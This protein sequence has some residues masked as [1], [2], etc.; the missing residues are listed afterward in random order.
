MKKVTIIL[1]I[2]LFIF[3]AQSYSQ[4]QKK[5]EKSPVK[6]ALLVID[7]QKAYLQSIS[8]SDRKIAFHYING[9]IDLF[10]KNGF[11]V[12]RIYHYSKE[13]G[14][15]QGSEQFEFDP[16]IQIKPEDTK[17]IKTYPDAFNKT[18]L[19]KVLKEKG[20][21]T[22]FLC[23]LSAVGCVLATWIGAMDFD[24]QAFL[25]KDAMMSHNSTY[26]DNVETMFDAVSYDMVKLIVENSVK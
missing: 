6:P 20:C 25:I 16:D 7:V 24:Y 5:T 4:D 3:S 9:L 21:N 14:P 17:V 13:Y 12:I 10:R 19:D 26:T 8:E 23:G 11:P 18:D 15:E 2:L 22:V 1:N